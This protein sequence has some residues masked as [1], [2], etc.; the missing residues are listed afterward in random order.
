MYWAFVERSEKFSEEK[1]RVIGPE[2]S[3][4]T[5]PEGV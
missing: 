2:N 5:R 1:G 3:P 4:I